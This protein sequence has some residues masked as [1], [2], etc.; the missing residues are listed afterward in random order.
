LKA[1]RDCWS[2][3]GSPGRLKFTSS[4]SWPASGVPFDLEKPKSPSRDEG[5]ASLHDA[6]HERVGRE[7]EP[8]DVGRLD[9]QWR[10]DRLWRK[11]E[12]RPDG[13]AD[14]LLGQVQ[15]VRRVVGRSRAALVL[16]VLRDQEVSLERVVLGRET[17][18]ERIAIAFGDPASTAAS[19]TG[20]TSAIEN[21]RVEN[22]RIRR[23][24]T[25]RCVPSAAGTASRHQLPRGNGAAQGR[26]RPPN[27]CKH[28]DV[29]SIF[30]RA[31]RNLGR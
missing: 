2:C 7:V 8:D 18:A 5:G 15:A 29:S 19:A 16:A 25:P 22:D 30:G 11:G 17:D 12:D 20:K 13:L 6:G 31:A 24:R 9:R 14:V 27:V 4:M 21:D 1:N 10:R 26:R 3:R 23:M 28:R